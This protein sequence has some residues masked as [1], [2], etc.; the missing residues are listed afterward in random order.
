MSRL[1]HGRDSLWFDSCKRPP[2]VCDHSVFAFW[3][4][5]YRTFDCMRLNWIFLINLQRGREFKP[6]KP[7]VGV[8]WILFDWNNTS[9]TSLLNT[10]YIVFVSE[11]KCI[12]QL[13][14]SQWRLKLSMQCWQQSFQ[15]ER[16]ETTWQLHKEIWRDSSTV[17]TEIF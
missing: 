14:Q 12:S 1:L 16:R 17:W 7:S 3:V 15:E 2:P 8:V 11:K 10:Q 4:V 5:T 9:I 6:K 13:N